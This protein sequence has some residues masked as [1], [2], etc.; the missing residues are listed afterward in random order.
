M[1]QDV[2]KMWLEAL[3]SG[4]YEQTKGKLHRTEVD[5]VD[6]EEG[7]TVGY[8]CL[9]VLCDLAV[10]EGVA[11]RRTGPYGREEFGDFQTDDIY[12]GLTSDAV[13][14]RRVMEWAGLSD[15]NPDVELSTFPDLHAKVMET[16]AYMRGPR[17]KASL[18][19]INDAGGTFPEIAD[20]I[21]AVL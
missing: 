1:N 5:D 12:G 2:K 18:A 16:D 7:I 11:E 15:A 6:E 21:E 10:K 4:E 3:R 20:V 8:C 9:G 19:T 14:P 17:E 13:L